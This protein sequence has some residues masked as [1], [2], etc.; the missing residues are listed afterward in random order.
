MYL[1]FIIQFVLI[2][3]IIKLIF[4]G[5]CSIWVNEQKYGTIGKMFTFK[6]IKI[7]EFTH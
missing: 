6:S 1:K 4:F 5:F 3:L 2:Y 7:P